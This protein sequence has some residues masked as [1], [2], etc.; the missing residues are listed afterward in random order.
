[1]S[2]FLDDMRGS[3]MAILDVARE[4][5]ELGMAFNLTGNCTIGNRLVIL[6]ICLEKTEQAIDASVAAEL[7][8]SVR[9]AEKSSQAILQATLAGAELASDKQG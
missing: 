5:R 4:L 9:N 7:D 2:K 8:E 3:E 1:M 6:A